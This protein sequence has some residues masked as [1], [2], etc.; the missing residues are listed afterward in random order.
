MSS[1]D[2]ETAST[3]TASTT[4]TSSMS[5][6]LLLSGI[7]YS[8]DPDVFTATLEESIAALLSANAVV[9]VTSID[10]VDA[11]RRRLQPISVQYTIVVVS[12]CDGTCDDNDTSI[13]DQV[14]QEMD[15]GFSSGNLVQN[16]QS[17]AHQNGVEALENIEIESVSVSDEV[18]IK[19]EEH[20]LVTFVDS[21]S[22]SA[23]FSNATQD[24]IDSAIA[25][26]AESLRIIACPGGQS[27]V[28]CS[29]EMLS[30]HTNSIRKIR[31]RRLSR[32]LQ[33]QS[34]MF[35]YEF[36]IEVLC[37]PLSGCN[38]SIDGTLKQQVRNLLDAAILQ[39]SLVRNVQTIISG[40]G[41][42][43][44]GNAVLVTQKCEGLGSY[45]S[46]NDGKS[47]IRSETIGSEGYYPDFDGGSGRC[48]NDGFA[49][50]YTLS[51]YDDIE[52]C[53]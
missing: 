47:Y 20:K 9:T 4:T 31:S 53:W 38:D 28:S 14:K 10:E 46:S 45:V 15:E 36:S 35:D 48:L 34:L 33:S 37:D 42:I 27:I 41:D 18:N 2:A 11:R 23:D 22:F 29:V 50:S 6:T 1:A 13:L 19:V 24:E 39:G 30:M 12:E 16:I 25:G 3:T 43:N 21:I 44:F 49:P 7:M 40:V 17:L 32:L 8:G 5:A 52:T 26:I 51:F